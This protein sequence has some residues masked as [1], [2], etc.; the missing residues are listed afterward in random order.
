MTE[1]LSYLS[2]GSNMGDREGYLRAARE[3]L[4]A[5]PGI[6]VLRSSPLYHTRPVGKTDQAWFLNQ[7]VEVKT[8]LRPEELL[9]TCQGIEEALGRVRHERWGPRTLDIDILTYGTLQSDDPHLTLPHP[10]MLERAFV[11]VPLAA[12]APE[13]QIAGKTVRK[14][15]A[16]LPSEELDGVVPYRPRGEGSNADV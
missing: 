14:Y 3:R 5:A 2:L 16:A 4:A 8:N 1:V 13:M 9:A 15:L 11:L 10:R 12:I 6:Q 7:V